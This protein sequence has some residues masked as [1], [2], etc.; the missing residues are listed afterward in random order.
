MRDFLEPLQGS[1]V[2]KSLDA[3]RKSTVK[4]EKLIFNNCSEGQEVEQFGETF[5][6]IWVTVFPAAFV[7]ESINLSDLSAFMVSSEDCDSI[8]IPHF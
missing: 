2:V 6:D 7:I 4:T 3:G 5:P 1:D 8:F